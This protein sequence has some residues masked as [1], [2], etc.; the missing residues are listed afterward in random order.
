VGAHRSLFYHHLDPHLQPAAKPILLCTHLTQRLTG[1]S[2]N[3]I[4]GEL[5][6]VPKVDLFDREVVMAEQPLE[7]LRCF[8]WGEVRHELAPDV[9][10]Q[11]Q[12]H[13]GQGRGHRELCSGMARTHTA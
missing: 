9:R 11:L 5:L 10:E 13:R 3:V 7:G 1:Y 6:P 2:W 12:L 8:C 4:N